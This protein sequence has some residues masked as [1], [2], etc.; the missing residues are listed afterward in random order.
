MAEYGMLKNLKKFKTFRQIDSDCA[1]F[2]YI[3]KFR[4]ENEGRFG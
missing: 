4:T 2:L 3:S 1:K